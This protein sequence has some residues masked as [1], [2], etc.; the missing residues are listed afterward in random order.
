MSFMH[1]DL[2]EVQFAEMPSDRRSSNMEVRR[3]Q[4]QILSLETEIDALEQDNNTL[5]QKV[6]DHMYSAL[7]D[8]IWY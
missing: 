7:A 8:I 2:G 4:E 1:W 6:K 3:L 5:A